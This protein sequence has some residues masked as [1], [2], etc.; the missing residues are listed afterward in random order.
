MFQSLAAY[1]GEGNKLMHL[2]R[3]CFTRVKIGAH[4]EFFFWTRC[5]HSPPPSTVV[6][7]DTA[8]STFIFMGAEQIKNC[9]LGP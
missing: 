9:T 1:V 4:G 2:M 7:L 8:A 3:E 5:S 6:F